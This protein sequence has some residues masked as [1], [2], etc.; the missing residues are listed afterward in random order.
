[1]GPL[2]PILDVLRAH[3]HDPRAI[4]SS[5][6]FD[7]SAFDDPERR[8]TFQQ[9]GR[10]IETCVAASGLAHFG[11]LVAHRFQLP[12][13]GAV[14]PL[15]RGR[16]S[17][18]GALLNLVRHLHLTDRGAVPFLI[19]LGD[20][21]VALGYAVYRHDTPGLAHIYDLAIGAGHRIMQALCGE[22]WRATEITFSHAA[23][24]NPVPWR[25]FFGAPVRFD[26]PHSE[27]VFAAD[28]LDRPIA[29]AA[30]ALPEPATTMVATHTSDRMRDRV[31][32]A[33]QGLVLTGEATSARVAALVGIHERVLRRRLQ[34]EGTSLQ[35]LVNAA[36]HDTACQLLKQTGLPVA[37]IAATLHYSDATAFS[38]AFR[39]VA[40]MAPSAWRALHRVPPPPADG[41]GADA[42]AKART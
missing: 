16:D 11:L 9:A 42:I 2:L 33:V 6:G 39:N 3:G 5:A 29:G 8:V 10:L 30:Q 20:A 12:A 1:M 22:Q 14:A 35:A 17:V 28:W 18:R 24:R 21:Q 36:R 40:G 25:R 19:D 13:L 32:R 31:R 38:R 37:E 7:L 34:A 23:P 26:A 41:A 15:L 4:C 27:L